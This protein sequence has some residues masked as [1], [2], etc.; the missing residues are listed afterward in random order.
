MVERRAGAKEMKITTK[1][2]IVSLVLVMSFGAECTTSVV[3]NSS[4]TGNSLDVA[5]RTQNLDKKSDISKNNS[6]MKIVVP[7]PKVKKT[8]KKIRKTPKVQPQNDPKEEKVFGDLNFD[9]VRKNVKLA[10]ENSNDIM[11]K[12][13]LTK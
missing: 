6:E 13:G 8:K 11:A 12:Y 2:A 7:D 3:E 4:T 9:N 10:F 5:P 1:A